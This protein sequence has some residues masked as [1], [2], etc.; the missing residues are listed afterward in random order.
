[1]PS[2]PIHRKCTSFLI[3]T[4][5]ARK[6][7]SPQPRR[8]FNLQIETYGAGTLLPP[9]LRRGTSFLIATYEARKPSSPQ[10]RRG[11]S[12]QIETY[13]AG[14]LLSPQPRRGTS[15]LIATHEA[16]KP[17]SPQPR[18]GFHLL[19]TPYKPVRAQCGVIKAK[20]C[21]ARS[22][23]PLH[24]APSYA[25]GSIAPRCKGQTYKPPRTAYGVSSKGEP[26]RGSF[27]FQLTVRAQKK[28]TIW[29]KASSRFPSERRFRC[30]YCSKKPLRDSFLL[31]L[32]VRKQK[33][34]LVTQPIAVGCFDFLCFLT[35]VSDLH[36]SKN[37]RY[38]IAPRPACRQT[39]GRQAGLWAL[40]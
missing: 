37:K 5:E 40:P 19:L 31:P 15:F 29:D 25:K 23:A 9:Q 12:L 16:R 32:T 14:T 21:A 20:G 3:A 8:G 39:R 35:Q 7:S 36:V 2:S 1:M 26:H 28:R 18:R 22:D 27:P 17:S 33:N 6:P 10:P 13:G 4:H 34:V 38:I 11:F 30:T 24:A